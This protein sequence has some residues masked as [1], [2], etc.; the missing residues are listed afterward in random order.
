MDDV[1]TPQQP[2]HNRNYPSRRYTHLLAAYYHPYT[3]DDFTGHLKTVIGQNLRLNALYPGC[4]R[5]TMDK[6]V[7]RRDLGL[8]EIMIGL[9]S[10]IDTDS[11]ND[12]S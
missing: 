9:W 8:D 10:E 6:E 4:Y 12:R 7:T 2:N 5:I 1:K 11:Y 3:L